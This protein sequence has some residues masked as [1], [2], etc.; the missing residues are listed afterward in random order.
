MQQEVLEVCVRKCIPKDDIKS[1]EELSIPQRSCFHRCSIK[2][3][4]ALRFSQDMLNLQNYDIKQ[5]NIVHDDGPQPTL[6]EKLHQ[7]YEEHYGR[8]PPV[9]I[10]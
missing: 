6:M 4:E 7:I 3:L 5:A 10:P 8:Q 2:Y 1:S 9:R